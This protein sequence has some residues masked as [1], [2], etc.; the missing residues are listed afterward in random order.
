MANK[1]VHRFW[2]EIEKIKGKSNNLQLSV[3]CVSGESN[4]ANLYSEKYKK[5]FSSVSYDKA[6]MSQIKQKTQESVDCK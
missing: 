1:T 5:L 4:I 2:A 6:Q 3:D